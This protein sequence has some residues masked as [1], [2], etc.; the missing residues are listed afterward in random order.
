MLSVKWEE[1]LGACAFT[2]ITSVVRPF[3]LPLGSKTPLKTQGYVVIRAGGSSPSQE[4]SVYEQDKEQWTQKSGGLFSV[5][6]SALRIL[7]RANP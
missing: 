1:V 5:G 3:L 6:G 4:R 7:P 2:K